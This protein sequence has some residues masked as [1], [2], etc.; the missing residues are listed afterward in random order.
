MQQ[1]FAKES[2]VIAKVRHLPLQYIFRDLLA[3]KVAMTAKEPAFLA[4]DLIDNAKIFIANTFLTLLPKKGLPLPEIG[5]SLTKKTFSLCPRR[6]RQA[7]FPVP[8][9]ESGLKGP[10]SLAPTTGHLGNR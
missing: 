8:F 3:G 6:F 9:F 1:F 4:R 2:R 7:V 10:L 5:L